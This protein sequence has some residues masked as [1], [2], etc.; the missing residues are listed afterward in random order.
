VRVYAVR[1]E[2]REAREPTL[3]LLPGRNS[4]TRWQ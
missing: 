2:V 3:G 1:M 4:K